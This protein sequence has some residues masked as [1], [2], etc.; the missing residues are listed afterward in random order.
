M[1][2]RK[3]V[4]VAFLL[5]AVMLLGVGY[6]ALTDT[7]TI[8]GNAHIDIDTANKTFDEKVYFSDAQPTSTTGT[9][10]A[11][12][13]ANCE[14]DDATFTANK[15][16]TVG[17]QSVFTFT[18][19]ND[20]NVDAVISVGDKK[21]SGDANPSNSNADKFKVEYSYPQGMNIT[22]GGGTITVVVTVTVK[23]PVTAATSATFGIELT[24]TSVDP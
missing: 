22:K 15:L 2:N 9:G 7:L 21:L 11:A 8:I 20:S 10:A 24:A 19:K 17:Q 14:G 16:A 23:E 4:V 13:I 6:A 1:K 5:V 12:D 18:I 3:F